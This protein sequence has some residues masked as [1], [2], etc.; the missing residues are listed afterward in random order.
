MNGAA[1]AR[2]AGFTLIEILVTIVILSI[3][4]LGIA[5]MQASSLRNNHAAYTKTQAANL[6]MDMADRIRANPDGR[7]QYADFD[8]NGAIPA[9]P[10]CIDTGCAPAE[11][12][13]Y[14]QYEWSIPI[15]GINGTTVTE[16]TKPALPDGRGIIKAD[17]EQFIVTLIWREPAYEGMDRTQCN[18]DHDPAEYAC[19]QMRFLP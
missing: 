19:F 5:G 4:L 14:D 13:R 3:G 6:A 12:A 11:L 18:E 1:P 17:G 16:T 7:A 9:A 8:T 2:Q 10:A 15:R